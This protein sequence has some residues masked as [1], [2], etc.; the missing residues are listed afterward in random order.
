[1]TSKSTGRHANNNMFAA[2]AEDYV[3]TEKASHKSPPTKSMPAPA[4]TRPPRVSHTVEVPTFLATVV[5]VLEMVSD[6]LVRVPLV[7]GSSIVICINQLRYMVSD[8]KTRK[9]VKCNHKRGLNH[10]ETNVCQAHMEGHCKASC[11]R[12]WLH[13]DMEKA[14]VAPQMVPTMDDFVELTKPSTNTTTTLSD[15]ATVA[16]RHC[17]VSAPVETFTE[18]G[19]LAKLL[20][21]SL[22]G[23]MDYARQFTQYT[24]PTKGIMMCKSFLMDGECQFAKCDFAHDLSKQCTSLPQKLVKVLNKVSCASEFLQAVFDEIQDVISDNMHV[25]HMIA[26]DELTYPDIQKLR[27]DGVSQKKINQLVE[28][29]HKQKTQQKKKRYNFPPQVTMRDLTNKTVPLSEIN[30]LFQTWYTLACIDHSTFRLFGRPSVTKGSTFLLEDLVW[31]IVRVCVLAPCKTHKFYEKKLAD[32][33]TLETRDICHGGNNCKRGP[34]GEHLFD[35]YAIVNPVVEE[36]Q[37]DP[38]AGDFVA[39]GNV[40]T[41]AAPLLTGWASLVTPTIEELEAAAAKERAESERIAAEKLALQQIREAARAKFLEE[42]RVRAL[43]CQVVE[44]VEASHAPA[45]DTFYDGCTFNTPTDCY[46]YSPIDLSKID[47]TDF[48][49]KLLSKK[50]LK[51]WH[52]LQR[53]NSSSLET[54]VDTTPTQ[55]SKTL[56]SKKSKKSKM[57]VVVEEKEESFDINADMAYAL[58]EAFTVDSS[59]WTIRHARVNPRTASNSRDG[60]G[61]KSGA[62]IVVV[63]PSS[64]LAKNLK[65]TIGGLSLR[66]KGTEITIALKQIGNKEKAE[67]RVHEMFSILARGLL[68][69]GVSLEDINASDELYE[70]SFEDVWSTKAQVPSNVEESES[71][72]ES[73]SEEEEDMMQYFAKRRTHA[74]IRPTESERAAIEA[75]QIRDLKNTFGCLESESSSEEYS[76]DEDDL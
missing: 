7:D 74:P 59:A 70:V 73:E 75:E 30:N 38:T 6:S 3:P 37:V 44:S 4:A 17:H 26:A 33:E 76:S 5:L 16:S 68:A 34:H 60:K 62:K 23:F 35:L 41:V 58:D 24:I 64:E 28:M 49:F 21:V 61:G 42:R 47:E 8:L 72:S 40:T 39:L 63:A 57:S 50:E 2:L 69:M 15:W 22:S 66:L 52:R 54:P 51:E 11:R 10:S 12:K 13:I 19:L 45:C 53:E 65:N 46:D 25:Y 14:T 27:A 48:R 32:G 31:E 29:Y 67:A 56:R 71:E 36:K 55:S 9:S 18:N 1:M 20:E 43:E